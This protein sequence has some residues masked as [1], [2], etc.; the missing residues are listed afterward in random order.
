MCKKSQW[1][2]VFNEANDKLIRVR[3]AEISYK[4]YVN[5]PNQTK[6]SNLSTFVVEVNVYAQ[7]PHAPTGTGPCQGASVGEQAAHPEDKESDHHPLK[8][9]KILNY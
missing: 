1:P 9:Q 8:V 5:Y 6:P 4:T 2:H 7:H 3:G